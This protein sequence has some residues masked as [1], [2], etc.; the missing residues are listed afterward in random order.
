MFLG[1]FGQRSAKI[2]QLQA[3][4]EAQQTLIQSQ[5]QLIGLQVEKINSQLEELKALKENIA[6]LH[7]TAFEATLAKLNGS[8]TANLVAEV[9]SS[10]LND[11]SFATDIANDMVETV[12]E[13]VGENLDYEDLLRNVEIS[14][15]DIA[16]NLVGNLDLDDL[17]ERLIRQIDLDNIASRVEVDMSKFSYS[18]CAEQISMYDLAQEIDTSSLAEEIGVDY[19]NLAEKLD[20]DEIGV[21][22]ELLAESLAESL[23]YQA[24]SARLDINE[25]VSQININAVIE[26]LDLKELMSTYHYYLD[27]SLF[28]QLPK[29]ILDA[30]TSDRSQANGD[31]TELEWSILMTVRKA[32]EELANETD[33]S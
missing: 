25:I 19:E 24:I 28:S 8:A 14:H 17:T 15:E 21:D 30:T 22:Y 32:I 26:K 2:A 29:A 3:Q 12:S 23:D 33:E 9:R 6:S 27:T 1:L 13:T 20:H 18:E 31:W 7:E 5:G 11:P 10:I 16:D 4:L